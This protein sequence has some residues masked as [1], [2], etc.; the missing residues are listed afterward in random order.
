MIEKSNFCTVYCVID[1]LDECEPD[2]LRQ[3]L[4]K[5]EQLSNPNNTS[6][7]KVRL[8]CLSR[9]FPERIPESLDL[10]TKIEL[11]MMLAG[12]ADMER[13]ITERVSTLARK[14]K[15]TGRLKACVEEVFQTKSGGT[16]LWVSFMAKDLED[17]SI[18]N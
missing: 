14:K 10:F 9:W 4:T 8:V 12:K 15:M 11:D 5:F 3:L 13:F 6:P 7:K 17:K 16:F 2:L 1:A 18:S